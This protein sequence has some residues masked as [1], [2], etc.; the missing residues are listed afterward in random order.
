MSKTIVARNPD[1]D[2]YIAK[3][4]PFAQPILTHVRELVHK[5]VPGI[6]EEIKWSRPFFVY[7][8][9]IL[10]NVS[11]FKAHCSVGLWGEDIA[12]KL[13]DEGKLVSNA[14]G[15]LGRLTSVAELPADKDLIGYWK[16]GAAA[17]DAGTR[18]VSFKRP[19]RVAK[20][21]AEM[22]AELEAALK[23]N[24]KAL[25]TFEAFPPSCRREYIDWIAGAKQAATRERRV[26]K[27]VA[28]MAE[29]KRH[30]WQY[31]TC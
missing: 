28:Q 31:E 24:A 3:A 10:G 8:G 2:A 13:R 17:I 5:A 22:P 29:G 1:V 16:V 14:M 18:T 27:A 30:N 4:A 12:A 25:K 19:Q 23:K 15:S 21:E 7:Q 9:I 26:V 11:A 6:A 20:K